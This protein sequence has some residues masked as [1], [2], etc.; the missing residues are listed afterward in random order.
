MTPLKSKRI[1]AD[2]ALWAALPMAHTS[3]LE[4]RLTMILGKTCARRAPTRRALL[5]ALGAGAAALVPLAMLQPVA[6]A[7]AAPPSRPRPGISAP[8]D[9]AAASR[10]L[11]QI[12]VD[13]GV[14]QRTHGGAFPATLGPNSLVADMAA[15]PH[16]YGL[17]DQ[18]AGNMEQAGRSFTSPGS[19]S[20]AY[21][22]HNKRPDGT[23][24]GTARGAGARDVFADTGLFVRNDRAMAGFWL[25]LWD[26]GMVGKVPT[27]KILAVRAYD[28]IGPPGATERARREGEKQMAFPGQAGLPRG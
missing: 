20:V 8:E 14:Y 4:G 27:G 22:L 15:A 17:P 5:S 9:L 25:V 3:R 6:R 2:L 28:I 18:G 1:P 13:I 24:K 16:R 26:D 21:L 19:P 12:Y 7:Q 23:L 10:H 11:Q